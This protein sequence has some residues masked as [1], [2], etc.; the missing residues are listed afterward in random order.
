MHLSVVDADQRPVVGAG[1]MWSGLDAAWIESESAW[2][3]LDWEKLERSSVSGITD[4]QGGVELVLPDTPRVRNVLWVSHPEFAAFGLAVDEGR[5]PNLPS[6]VR[7]LERSQLRV[8]VNGGTTTVP[9]SVHVHQVADCSEVALASL[10]VLARTARRA[11]HR[12]VDTDVNG[13]AVLTPLSGDQ[14]LWATCEALHSAPW[15]GPAPAEVELELRP[16]FTISGTVAWDR[17][18]TPSIAARV[19]CSSMRSIDREVLASAVVRSDGSFGELRLP[20]VACDSYVVELEGASITREF[21]D[22]VDPKPGEH[23]TL[24]FTTQVGSA[25]TIRVIG[26]D[27]LG[28][29][30]AN[31]SAQWMEGP[32]WR[33][34]DRRTNADG[35]AALDGIPPAA[36]W[37]R[38]RAGGF[39]PKLMPQIETDRHDGSPIV[40]QLEEAGVVDGQCLLA[41]KPARDFTVNFW[42]KEPK[43]GGKLEVRGSPDGRF[44]VDEAAPGELVLF[45]MGSISLQSPQVRVEVDVEKPASC[46]L[47][48]PAPCSATGRVVDGMTGVPLVSG[49]VAL[50]VRAGDQILRAWK[51]ATPVDAGGMFVI[52]GLVP[53]LNYL[54]VTAEGFA[55]RV[56]DIWVG[57]EAQVDIGVIGLHGRGSLEVKLVGAPGQ[58]FSGIHVD[59]QGVELRP[60][61]PVPS[62]GVV[63]FDGLMPGS[64]GPRIVFKDNSTRFLSARLAPG[65]HVR[66]TTPVT[67]QGFEVQVEP[68]TAELADR[69]Y[70]LRVAFA[71]PDGIDGDEFYPIRRGRNVLV[72]TIDARRIYLEANDRDGVVLGVGR[73]ELTGAS[74]ETVHFRVDGRSPVLR[75]VNNA[76]KPI[77]G[78]RVGLVGVELDATWARTSYTDSDGLCVLEG[79]AFDSVG[80]SLHHPELGTAPIKIVELP[81][82]RPDPIE[83]VLDAQLAL[84]IRVIDRATPLAGIELFA[85][86]LGRYEDGLGDLGSDESGFATWHQV[87]AGTYEVS[88]VHPGI[89]PDVARVEV[90]DSNEPVPFQVRRLGNVAF[91]VST[92]LGNPVVGARFELDCVERATSVSAWIADGSVPAPANGLVTDEHGVL[93]VRGLPNGEFRYRATLPTGAVLEGVVTVPPAGTL[94]APLRVE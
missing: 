54:R 50:Q 19:T 30:N 69:L 91:R 83:L 37:I 47:E 4:A 53:G 76:R 11:F 3:G 14:R 66:I 1:V 25:L 74:G 59:L 26:P 52:S 93:T 15:I 94:D 5:D 88:V 51:E 63:R 80:I 29:P 16:T 67:D 33:R 40:V 79:V 78:A 72:R 61:V 48:L 10:D 18:V 22:L 41:G 85:R 43:D 20:I 82:D 44:R 75:V 31:V 28:V 2:P 45:A 73:F 64:Y 9:S 71:T 38:V 27:A 35:V 84:R 24:T 81:H 12:T 62:S 6:T 56:A 92:T 60:F 8:H 32:T 86:D 7:L 34:L 65:R 57:Q 21:A 39:V 58:D 90:K 23:R 17:T 68:A 87:A 55:P 42:K 46:T 36:V 89:W 70:E 77:A 13:R 49:R